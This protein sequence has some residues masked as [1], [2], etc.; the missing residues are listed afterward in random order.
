MPQQNFNEKLIARL[1]KNPDFV[2][3]SGELLPAAVKDHAWKLD[4]TLIRLL[5]SDPDIKST[6]FDEIDGHW[7]FNHN[8][9]I[10]Y[11]NEKNFLANSYTQFRNKIGLNIDGKFLRERGEVSLVWPYKDCVLEGGQTKEEEKRKEIF[12]NEILAQD[13]I[14][15]MFDPKVLTNWKRHT[16]EGEQDVTDIRCDE[17]GTIRENLIIKGNNL[18][19]LHTLKQQFRGQ[20]KLIYIDPPYN[21]GSDSFGYNDS[22]NHSSWL[23]FMRNRLEVAKELLR[24][25]GVI[26]VQCDDNQTAY[27]KVLMDE[28]FEDAVYATTIYIQVRYGQKTLSEKNDFQKLIEQIHI[29]H[30]KAFTPIKPTEEYSIEKFVWEIIEK[31]E[32]QTLE[33]GSKSA[34]LFKPGEYEIIQKESSLT[35]LKETWATGTVLKNNASGKFF[36]SYIAPRVTIDGLGC[37]YKVEGIGEDGLGYRYFTGPKR[38][39]ATKGKFYS[40]IPTTRL[41]ELQSGESKKE[42]VIPNFYNFAD[43]FG[44][45]RHEGGVELRSGKKP[46]SLLKL[47]IEMTTEENDIVLDFFCGTGTTLAVSHKLQRFYIGIEQLDYHENDSVNR[48]KNVIKGDT[49]G[50]SNE[51]GFQGGGDFIYCELMQYNQTCIEKI[52]DAQSS[53]ELVE[54]WGDIAEN[55]FL[56]W[57]VNAE[58]PEEAADNFIA[59]D[60]LEVQKH[61]LIELLDKNQLYVNLSE[62][63]DTDF[64]VSEADKALNK[65]FY[66]DSH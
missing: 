5:L 21:T 59:I 38:S 66:G 9:F 24:N 6:F 25:D 58:N 45:C 27:L 30:K 17:N 33:L 19:A 50:I 4:H 39:G 31:S 18:I 12:F 57:Y 62:I 13:E 11:I 14:D 26:F 28:I 44:N 1:K 36:G 10:D 61:C 40:G 55:S 29:Y 8:T 16:A 54:L 46:E 65:V 43:G 42:L 52:Q 23:T 41:K 15:Q 22:F 64:A 20:V 35:G 56:N 53:E 63:E 2:D 34:V 51:V 60:N 47:I 7:V 3:E 48:L 32:G 37:L 49:T